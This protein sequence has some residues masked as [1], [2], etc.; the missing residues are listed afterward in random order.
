MRIGSPV[1]V[2]VALV[3]G[4]LFS[5]PAWTESSGVL[6]TLRARVEREMFV[7]FDPLQR[8]PSAQRIAARIP[9]DRE[10][11]GLVD[12]LGPVESVTVWYPQRIVA[13]DILLEEIERSPRSPLAVLNEV[14]LVRFR[15]GA[16]SKFELERLRK[17]PRVLDAQLNEVL[18]FSVA[19]Y[20][21]SAGAPATRIEGKYQ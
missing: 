3:M 21:N 7:V 5:A 15:E 16:D 8:P 1:R 18:Q 11:A 17:D 10:A 14:L 12:L 19:D 2:S 13:D 4:V 6:P 9:E 20:G